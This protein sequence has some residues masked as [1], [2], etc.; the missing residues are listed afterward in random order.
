MQGF[1]AVLIELTGLLRLVSR[2]N[3]K[4]VIVSLMARISI[5]S[6]LLSTFEYTFV[7]WDIFQIWKNYCYSKVLVDDFASY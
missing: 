1:L 3:A 2:C 7:D 6:R 4:F 5:I